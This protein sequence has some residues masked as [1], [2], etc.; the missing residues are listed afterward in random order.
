MGNQKEWLKFEDERN[1]YSQLRDL[2][3]NVRNFVTELPL[4]IKLWFQ[5]RT[6]GYS[7]DQVWGLNS[8][9]TTYVYPRLK[10]FYRWQSEHGRSVPIDFEKDPASWLEVLRKMVRAFELMM[11]DD[12]ELGAE[13]WEETFGV[14]KMVDF[15][16]KEEYERA[17]QGYL[18]GQEKINKEIQ[19]GIELFGK[20][21]RNLWD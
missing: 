11:I 8:A 4:T 6:K 19:E 9:I 21:M 10:E 7:D 2:G 13:K 16:T 18:S 15:G 12:Y 3:W 20:Y 1:R 14:P 17:W 5:R